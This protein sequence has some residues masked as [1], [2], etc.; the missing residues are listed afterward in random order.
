M[1]DSKVTLKQHQELLSLSGWLAALVGCVEYDSTDRAAAEATRQ[2]AWSLGED[3]G[4]A[5]VMAWSQEMRAWFALTRGDYRGVLAAAEVGHSIAPNSRAA[6]QLHAQRAK[7]WA[8]IGDRRQV[9]VALDQGRA[10]LE[11]M[12]YPDNL[13]NHFTVDPAK[14]DFYSMD[15]Y[16]ILGGVGAADSVENKLAES[17]AKEV[18]RVGTDIDGS[19]TA[20]MRVAEARITLG[21]VSARCPATLGV[22]M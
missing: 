2:A 7:A 12:P 1:L 3:S 15:C 11:R 9:E 10:L 21:V 5:E 17:Y 4:D 16:R 14:W 19:E 22:R 18:I 8:R 6:V 13:D 20:P